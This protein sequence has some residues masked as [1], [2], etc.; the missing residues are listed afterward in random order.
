MI[1]SIDKIKITERIRKEVT[2]I[3]EFAAEI[4]KDGLFHPVLVMPIGDKGEE[5][6]LLAGLRR[7]RA[8]E[9]NGEMEIMAHVIPAVDAEQ[10]LRI[11]FA[12]NEQR[13]QFTFSETMDYARLIEE[14]EEVKSL[15]RKS[16]GGKGGLN[17]DRDNCPYLGKGRTRDA[18]GEKFGMSGKQYER[19]KY[20]VK[21]AEPKVIEQL[22]KGEKTL[23]G[24]YKATLDK[25]KLEVDIPIVDAAPSK[26]FTVVAD[27]P[28]PPPKTAKKSKPPPIPAM[29]PKTLEE[30]VKELRVR[31]AEAESE[32]ANLK[33]THH[34]AVSHKNSIIENLKM[35]LADA[36]ARI[37]ELEKNS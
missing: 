25:K 22:D 32:L 26:T 4:K 30:E 3:P 21:N 11:E 33:V 27:E 5:Y 1:I 28:S 31:A 36:H 6:Q 24:A 9:L 20:I 37:E 16:A 7:L 19:A 10:A 12:E 2:D 8:V 34:N 17:E 35:Q 15:E 14:I 29:L 23:W 18:V 13:K